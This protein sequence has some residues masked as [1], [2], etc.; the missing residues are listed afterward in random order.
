MGTYVE[1]DAEGNPIVL[2]SGYWKES[3]EIGVIGDPNPDWSATIS[4]GVNYKGFNLNAQVEYIQGGD[5]LSYY[6]S[7]LLA[8]GLTEDTDVDRGLTVILPGVTPSGDKNTTQISLTD[9]YF[10]NYLYGANEALIYDGTLLRIREVSF[11]YKVPAKFLEKTPFGSI[12]I[13]LLANN[14]WRKAYNF[15]DAHQGMDPAVSSLGVGNSK[16][17][18]FMTGPA[19][20]RY[21]FSLK[22]SF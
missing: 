2:E 15:P 20:K 9:Y 22:M 11:G 3:S 7:T 14:L 10:D 16:G 21:G 12:S 5:I 1:R 4:T 8:R 6:A 19:S 17:L 18:D 13:T